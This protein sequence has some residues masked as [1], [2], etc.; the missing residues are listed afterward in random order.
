M[1]RTRPFEESDAGDVH[2]FIGSV[3]ADSTTWTEVGRTAFGLPATLYGGIAAT[4]ER[5]SAGNYTTVC[6]LRVSFQRSFLRGD[7]NDDGNVNLSDAICGLNWLFAA[8]PEPGCVAALN[9]NGDEDVDI[10]D[11]VSLLNFL[12]AG[13]P[14]PVAP[15]PDC[16]PGMLPAGAELGCMNPPN[17]Q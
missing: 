6:N 4:T 15:F 17:C 9:T 1:A 5:A 7:C 12:F 8:A 16:G 11:T 10:A 3:S 2:V 14:A 13:G